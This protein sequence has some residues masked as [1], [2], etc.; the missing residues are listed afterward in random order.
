MTKSD[1]AVKMSFM[2]LAL[3]ILGVYFMYDPFS[4][5]ISPSPEISLGLVILG[6]IIAAYFGFIKK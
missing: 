2:G 6:G 3:A 5:G 4:Y 1:D